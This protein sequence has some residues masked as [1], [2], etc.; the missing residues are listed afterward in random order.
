VICHEREIPEIGLLRAAWRPGDKVCVVHAV[1]RQ[2]EV[3]LTEQ[4]S[5]V[6]RMQ[7]TRMQVNI[8]LTEVLSDIWGRRDRRSSARSLRA[9][10]IRRLW[11]ATVTA[12]SDAVPMISPAH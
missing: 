3:L 7:K 9:N 11:P 10:A 1:A 2:R 8:Q 6:Q 5:W 4:G 12:G